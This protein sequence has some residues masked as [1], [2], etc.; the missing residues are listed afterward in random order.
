MGNCGRLGRIDA[1]G[2][3]RLNVQ[4]AYRRIKIHMQC[5]VYMGRKAERQ[6]QRSDRD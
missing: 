5:L 4:D 6:C 1:N 3:E 2:L